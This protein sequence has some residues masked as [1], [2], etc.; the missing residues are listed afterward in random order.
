MDATLI[1]LRYKRVVDVHERY[2]SGIF[3]FHRLLKTAVRQVGLAARR[4][5]VVVELDDQDL[6]AVGRDPE[7]LARLHVHPRRELADLIGP[8][9]FGGRGYWLGG[10]VG[11]GRLAREERHE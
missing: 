7:I 5:L 6:R 1:A 2:L 11:D 3:H 8:K 4:A 10:D 9:C